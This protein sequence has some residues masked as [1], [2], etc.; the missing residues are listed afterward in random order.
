MRWH[1]LLQFDTTLRFDAVL[2]PLCSL[3]ILNFYPELYTF[4]S[5]ARS[6]L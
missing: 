1:V 4:C 3:L 2:I 5:L 6:F